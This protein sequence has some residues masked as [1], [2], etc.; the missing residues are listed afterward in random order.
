MK[1]I[2][3][4]EVYEVNDVE[5]KGIDTPSLLVKSHWNYDDRV[6]LEYKEMRFTVIARDLL[7]AIANATRHK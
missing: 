1:V 4:I 6:V 2:S 5:Q 3:E 7:N